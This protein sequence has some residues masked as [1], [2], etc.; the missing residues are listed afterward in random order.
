MRI[1]Y[2]IL[3]KRNKTDKK[4]R[5][6]LITYLS[7]F[8]LNHIIFRSMFHS[9]FQSEFSFPYVHTLAT[10]VFYLPSRHLYPSLSL[11]FY[12]VCSKAIPPHDVT[13]QVASLLFIEGY[14]GLLLLLLLLLLLF[15]PKAGFGRNQSPVRRP[16]WLWHT[17]F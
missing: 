13:N 2:K 4:G 12:K 6:H 9:L 10:Y 3:S 16:V 8:K 11:S 5:W 15:S 1:F 17:A 14:V 7:N